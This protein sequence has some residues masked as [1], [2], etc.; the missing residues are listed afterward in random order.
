MN[1]P[2]WNPKYRT[3]KFYNKAGNVFGLIGYRGCGG[4]SVI[5]KGGGLTLCERSVWPANMEGHFIG[6]RKRGQARANVEGNQA[7]PRKRD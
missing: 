5:A 1:H 2:I 6:L 4:P 7:G 3:L